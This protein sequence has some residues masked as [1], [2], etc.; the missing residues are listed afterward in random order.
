MRRCGNEVLEVISTHRKVDIDCRWAADLAVEAEHRDFV[1][2]IDEIRA[3]DHI[4]L[5]VAA[6]A[7][8]RTEGGGEADAAYGS[9]RIEAVGEILRH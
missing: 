6:Q 2:R 3:L 9:Q 5:L 8:L 7:V 1:D 4:V